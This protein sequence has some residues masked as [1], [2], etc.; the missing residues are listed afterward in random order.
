[1]VYWSDRRNRWD[2]YEEAQFTQDLQHWLPDDWRSG[3][4][5]IPGYG[6]VLIPSVLES[7]A[8]YFEMQALYNRQIQEGAAPSELTIVPSVEYPVGTREFG[9]IQH[10]RRR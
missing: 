8:A 5:Y 4:L 3:V 9:V 10:P 2:S 7:Q 6:Y 1:M